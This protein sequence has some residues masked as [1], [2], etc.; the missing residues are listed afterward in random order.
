MDPKL[1]AA[2]KLMK[3]SF[4]NCKAYS[5]LIEEETNNPEKRAQRLQEIQ[6]ALDE[7]A[8]KEARSLENME[9]RYVR[10]R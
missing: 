1:H 5:L 8:R 10:G 2:L 7:A 9:N 4:E 3:V 6:G